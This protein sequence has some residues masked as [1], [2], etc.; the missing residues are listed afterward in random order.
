MQG[1]D[2]VIEHAFAALFVHVFNRV[3]RKRCGDRHLVVGQELRQRFLSWFKQNGEIAT[4]NYLDAKRAGL[5]Y[6]STEILIQFRCTP[7]EIKRFGARV[8]ERVDHQIHGRRIHHLGALRACGDMA[9]HAGLVA[10]VS[11]VHLQCAETAAAQRRKGSALRVEA[12]ENCVHEK[13]Y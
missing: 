8:F 10:L 5:L 6:E 12:G 9:M 3:A 11:E 1:A 13:P 4:V 7:R 2:A